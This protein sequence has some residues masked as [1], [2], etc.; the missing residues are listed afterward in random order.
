MS[1]WT[2]DK[3]R[4]AG[5]ILGLAFVVFVGAAVMDYVNLLEAWK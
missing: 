4:I 1:W 5:V 2:E 3:V